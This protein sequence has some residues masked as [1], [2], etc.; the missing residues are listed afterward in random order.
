V[1]APLAALLALVAPAAAVHAPRARVAV[2][3]LTRVAPRSLSVTGGGA[4]ASFRASG[5]DLLL[6]GRE[7]PEPH[8]LPARR[9][10]VLPSAAPAR[11][12]RAAL[13]LRAEGGVL[14][15]RA[16]MELEE[17]VAEVVASET[18]PGT[19]A[20]A[21]A[22]QAVVVRSYAL[23]ARGRH[24]GGALCD[25][26]HCQVLRARG[27][28]RG[29]LAA[30]RAAAGATA[31]EVLT[32][33]SGAVALTPFHAACGG[34]TADPREAFGGEGTGAA[35]ASDPGCPARPWR[36]RIDGDALARAV[37]GAAARS[38]DAAAAG[39]PARLRASDLVLVEGRGAWISR[40]STRDGRARLSGD[41]FARAVDGALGWG[42]VR[43]SRFALG[44]ADGG[45]TF[46][47]TGSGHG[48][49]LCQ[50]GAARRAA[51]G[52]DHRVILRH[53]FPLA[54]TAPDSS[55]SPG[56]AGGEGRGEG[57]RAR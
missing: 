43:S 1:I 31:G 27:L 44:E 47:G 15:V 3:V 25:L 11:T 17:Y 57:A 20:E 42:R 51:A 14:R 32:L 36:A 40:V 18:V 12:Y 4:R 53:Y 34:H 8:R 22:A 33:P 49:G 30:A 39:L 26:A 29:H 19:P 21:L 52:E 10:R 37:R 55:L 7:V 6:D 48:V 54:G 9:W 5:D 46:R 24:A 45:V 56:G 2:E 38:G 35:S 50:A 13:E 23:A 41:A 28:G 16:E